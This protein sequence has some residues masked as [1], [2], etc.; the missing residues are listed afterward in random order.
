[1][2]ILKNAGHY[3]SKLV[4]FKTR[5]N[6]LIIYTGWDKTFQVVD[7]S[8]YEWMALKEAI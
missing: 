1:V 6:Q 8:D 2:K 4:K 7:M 3:M 5:C